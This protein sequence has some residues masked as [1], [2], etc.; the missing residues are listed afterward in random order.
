VSSVGLTWKDRMWEFIPAE[1]V[2]AVGVFLRRGHNILVVVVWELAFIK[3]I[4]LHFGNVSVI[5]GS[6]QCLW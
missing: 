4:E 6:P 3:Q 2:G 1:D 5:Y